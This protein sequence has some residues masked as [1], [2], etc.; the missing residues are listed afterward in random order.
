MKLMFGALPSHGHVYPSI[1]LA[2]AAQEAGHDV[3][4]AAGEQFLPTLRTAGLTAVPVGMP[5][6]E[7]LEVVMARD[8]MPDNRDEI[9]AAILADVLPRRWATDLA[10]VVAAERPDV[11]VYDFGTLGAGLAGMAAGIPVLCHQGGRV[12][13][14]NLGDV[15]I[16]NFTA[17][18][19]EFGVQG[20]DMITN[21]VNIDICPESVQAPEF[22]K[23]VPR[24]PLRPVGWSEPGELPDNL[25]GRD[26][27]RPLVYLTLGTAFAEVGV[28]RS[29]VAGIAANPVDVIVSTG[30]GV[31]VAELGEVP[32]NVWVAP[33][34]PAP[35]L[36]PL[37]DLVVHHGG[38]GTML[39]AF[40]AGVPQLCLPQVGDHFPNAEA[41][42]TAGA[43]KTLQPDEVTKESVAEQ[44][45]AVL[46]DD[47]ARAAG[48]RL[49]NEIAAMPSPQDLVT[50]LPD[51]I[52]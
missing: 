41:V 35:K 14:T 25:A 29:A 8:P 34:V 11:I 24:A 40:A 32:D 17:C 44:V 2:I 5:M 36:F 3:V 43:G 45:K 47:D 39:G 46:A 13:S 9:I 27:K 30:P 23:Y 42:A 50:H 20:M 21:T 31:T 28:L 52:K 4:F 16:A 1:P 12:S 15:I 48:Q 49:A 26:R 7:A 37:V 51:I 18:A 10:P 38:S 33:W 22:L 6:Q 19:A